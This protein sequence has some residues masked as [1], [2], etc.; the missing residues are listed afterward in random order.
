MK[1]YEQLRATVEELRQRPRAVVGVEPVLLL[2]PHPRQLAA[3]PGE[4]VADPGVLLLASQQLVAGRLPFLAACDPVFSHR[5]CLLR[6]AP[7][8]ARSASR[9][10]S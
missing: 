3:P 1:W 10:R 6:L 8:D 4:L 7:S 9:T 2:D 5:V